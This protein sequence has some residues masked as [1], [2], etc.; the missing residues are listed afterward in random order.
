[1]QHIFSSIERLRVSKNAP[2]PVDLGFGI[3][4][5]ANIAISEVL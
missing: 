2:N 5:T 1:M 3:L 4:N